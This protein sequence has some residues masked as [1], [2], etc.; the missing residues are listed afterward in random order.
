MSRTKPKFQ[1]IYVEI[2]NTCN[3]NCP[4]CLKTTRAPRKMTLSDVQVI[5]DKIKKYTHSVYLHIKG[6]PLTHNNLEEIINVFHDNM[7]KVKVTTNGINIFDKGQF[8]LNHEGVNKINIS[9]QSVQN[10]N[11]EFIDK[12]Y[13]DLDKFLK[14][15]KKNHIYLR[16]W[17]LD[18]Q[19]K[20]VL[21]TRLLKMFPNA[22]FKDNELLDDY[23]HYSVQEKFEWPELNNESVNA[24]PCLG[25]R[26]QLGILSDGTIVLCC[27][28]TNGDTNLGN[29]FENELEDILNSEKYLNSIHKMPYL[30]L[31]KKCSY[32]TR[33]KK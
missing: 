31:C 22:K 30:E 32:R 16:N 5:A 8:L 33:F 26:N 19:E 21:E 6:E 20:Q 9:L 7:I 2:T 12:Y 15:T 18:D 23:I 3:L 25:G 28:D 10:L 17:A 29:I 4:F 24:T 14:S 27:L 13:E 11:K 1:Q